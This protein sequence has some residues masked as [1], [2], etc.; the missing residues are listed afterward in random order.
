MGDS[1]ILGIWAP[2]SNKLHIICLEFKVVSLAVCHW[3]PDLQ[4]HQKMMCTD[5]TMIVSYTCIINKLWDMVL[6]IAMS[7]HRLIP[8]ATLTGH[9]PL[10]QLRSGLLQCD[11]RPSVQAQKVDK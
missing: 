1:Q 2:T 3:N 7:S 11:H 5:N 4:D 8:I 9:S 6:F 10:G